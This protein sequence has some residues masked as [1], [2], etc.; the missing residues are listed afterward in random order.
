MIS[1]ILYGRN[2][3]Y[4]YNLHKRAVISLNSLALELTDPTDEIVFVDYNSPDE[5]PTFPEALR[6][7]LT[8]RARQL[9]RVI[10]VRNRL[11]RRVRRDSP[12]QLRECLAR[13]IGIRR[14]RPENRWILSTNPDMVFV[15]R[16][17]ISL[18]QVAAGLPD[19]YYSLPRFEMPESLWESVDRLAPREVRTTF[20]AWGRELHLDEVV[21][22][23]DYQGFDA[24]GD[25][26]LFP[27]QAAEALSGFNERMIYGWHVDSNL[28]KRM[29]LYFGGIHSLAEAY[30]GYHC[31]HTRLTSS[32]HAADRTEN[33]YHVDCDALTRPD[34]PE[35]AATWGLPQAVFEEI[36]LAQAPASLAAGL[37]E[38][39]GG[40][41]VALPPVAFVPASYNGHAY[42]NTV[43]TVPYVVNQLATLP[44][45][46][47]LAYLGSNT[48][49]VGLV[50][51]ACDR[52]GLREPLVYHQEL[53]A[54][55]GPPAVA[56]LPAGCLPTDRIARLAA[57]DVFLVDTALP[58]ET[59]IRN[60][61]GQPVMRLDVASLATVVRRIRLFLELALRQQRARQLGEA[62]ATCLVLGLQNSLYEDLYSRVVGFTAVPFACHYRHGFVR[63]DADIEGAL[64]IL[65]FLDGLGREGLADLHAAIR[66]ICEAPDGLAL[67]FA[68][69]FDRMELLI[70]DP[71]RLAAWCAAKPGRERRRP[72]LACLLL[73]ALA[74]RFTEACI[75]YA[76]FWKDASVI[77]DR[78][79]SGPGDVPL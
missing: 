66:D 34:L 8:A 39:L 14:A 17:E 25:F 62:P 68:A 3:N 57:A 45:T 73:Y 41:R 7:L 22:A 79:L 63:Q 53:M 55:A 46:T 29:A 16:R 74:G 18:S 54:A 40:R 47:R 4:G 70:N 58:P 60:R 31:D 59:A 36:R 1:V 28:C 50:R 32:G 76:K 64:A 13:N 75:V 48:E 20:A 24:P 33:N 12:L 67:D 27:R 9:L 44:A 61:H 42:Y 26:Q 65:A 10:R 71:P 43:H 77:P 52:I 69:A 35:Q 15:P 51:A 49:L 23:R 37:G 6:D 78:L 21:T 72:F 11:H 38:V 19:G 5:L 2:D 56:A 30:C